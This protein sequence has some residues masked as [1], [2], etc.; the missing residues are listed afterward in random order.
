MKWKQWDALPEQMRTEAV[1]PYYD[2][3]CQKRGSLVAK[4][5]FDVLVSG[6]MLLLLSPVFLVLALAVK[7]DTPGP[8]FTGRFGSRSMAGSSAFSNSA[9]WWTEPTRSARR[10][11][12][13]TTRG[14]Q[15][16][17]A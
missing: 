5:V 10:S 7:L 14:S 13:T 6:M 4:R 3:L 16:S 12:W 8:V 9:P 1:R 17:D 11:R 15:G 2:S